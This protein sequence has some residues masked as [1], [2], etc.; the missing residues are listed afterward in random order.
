MGGGGEGSPIPR[1]FLLHISGEGRNKRN[2]KNAA[3]KS[4]KR[5]REPTN[6]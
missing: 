6:R 4:R 2:A 5:E 1:V 3:E